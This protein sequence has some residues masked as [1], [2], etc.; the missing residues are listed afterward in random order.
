MLG[1]YKKAQYYFCYYYCYYY[2]YLSTNDSRTSFS[3]NLN[4]YI[5]L[6]YIAYTSYF[7]KYKRKGDVIGDMKRVSSTLKNVGIQESVICLAVN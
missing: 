6:I 7:E 1:K 3:K 2:H 4:N 5:I